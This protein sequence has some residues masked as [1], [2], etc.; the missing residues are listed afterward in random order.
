MRQQVLDYVRSLNINGFKVS[1]E[2]PFDSSGSPLYLKNSKTIYVDLAQTVTEPL[3]T[4]LNGLNINSETTTVSVYFSTDAK[5]TPSNFD[6]VI[7][8]IKG[9]KNL[10]TI[11]GINRREVDANTSFEGDLVV[12][13][14]ELRYFKLL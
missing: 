2:L 8:N 14:I 1:N 4:A 6:T 13:E 7:S 5:L 9:A 3:I 10:Q 12:S 11:E